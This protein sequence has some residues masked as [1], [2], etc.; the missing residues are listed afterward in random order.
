MLEPV[1]LSVSTGKPYQEELRR[2]PLPSIE[3]ELLAT[4]QKQKNDR[5]D[6]KESNKD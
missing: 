3:Q 6:N 4:I 5:E 1:K 2:Y